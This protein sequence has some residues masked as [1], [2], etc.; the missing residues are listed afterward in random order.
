MARQLDRHLNCFARPY[1]LAGRARAALI[2]HYNGIV[3]FADYNRALNPIT[4]ERQ[5]DPG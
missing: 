5:T 4:S 2:H 1:I 3:L